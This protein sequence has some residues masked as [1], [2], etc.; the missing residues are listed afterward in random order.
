[1][2]CYVQRWN[3]EINGVADVARSDAIQED[4]DWLMQ[5]SRPA[6]VLSAR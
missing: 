2:L 5:R 4:F 1:M 3:G 6:N